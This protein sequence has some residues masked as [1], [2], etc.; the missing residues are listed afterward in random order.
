M[1]MNS[2]NNTS[3]SADTGSTD[4]T[5]YLDIA[6]VAFAVLIAVLGI[7]GNLI[8]IFVLKFRIQGP[9]SAYDTILLYLAANDLFCA[10]VVPAVFVYGT[11]TEFRQWLTDEVG[12]KIVMSIMP[13]SISISQ[14]LLIVISVERFKAITKPLQRQNLGHKMIAKV[15]VGIFLC[16]ILLVLPGAYSYSI[17]VDEVYKTKTCTSPGSKR[18]F[19]L[20]F[21]AINLTKDLVCTFILAFSSHLIS[22][23]MQ[24]NARTQERLNAS[25]PGHRSQLELS[26]LRSKMLRNIVAGFSICAVPL[27]AFQLC[28]YVSFQLLQS[29]ITTVEYVWIR[30]INTVLYLLQ[31]SSVVVNIFIYN[32][33][34]APFRQLLQRLVTFP[35]FRRR[36]VSQT[37]S[38]ELKT[39]RTMQDNP[40][41]SSR[42]E[43]NSFNIQSHR[44]S[45]S[46]F[47][48][49]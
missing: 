19:M 41:F 31:V 20:A 40:S 49:I 15:F 47:S 45:T 11:L 44:Q 7:C 16:G 37:S 24:E 35:N 10:S 46:E 2:S 21:S 32:R 25:Q 18:P 34:Y 42:N 9:L 4:V 33:K 8:V 22:K 23:E 48:K 26:K 29:K 5:K 27:D 1:M 3:H 39:I 14:G 17:V 38:C 43:E 12:C 28:V 6:A 30:S 13:V 36:T